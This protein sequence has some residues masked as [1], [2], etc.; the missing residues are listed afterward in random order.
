M[1]YKEISKV[2]SNQEIAENIFEAFLYAPNISKI[3]KPGQF[4]N[5]L[6]SKSWSNVMRRPMSIASQENDQISIIYK[7][8]GEGT[9]LISKWNKGQDVDI[10]GP[11]GNYWNNY[12]EIT[13]VLIGGGV[14]IAPIMNLHNRLRSENIEHILIVGARHDK[15]HFLKHEPKKNIYLSTDNGDIG[16]NGNVIDVL[17]QYSLNTDNYK[18]FGCGPHP[19]MKALIEYSNINLLDCDLALETIMACGIGICQGC[20]IVKNVE[21]CNEHSYRNKFA[22]ACED[23]PI[24][25]VKELDYDFY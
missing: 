1:I 4:I 11:L 24:F 8:F 6:P 18:I 12:H 5:I 21:S 3:S 19:M 22:L 14:G 9:R 10:V 16:V 15:E 2:V 7:V 23:G 20:T 25:N 17:N 13:P